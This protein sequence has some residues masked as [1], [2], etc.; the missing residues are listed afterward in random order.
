MKAVV[1]AGGAGS[2]LRPLTINRPKPMVPIVNKPILMHILDLIKRHNITDII[3]TL[4]YM[5]DVIQ[6]YLGDGKALGLN[7]RYAIEES[8]LGT[9]GSV[10]NAQEYLDETFV[11]ISGD[12]LT[13]FDLTRIISYHRS[14]NALAT[15]TLYR[16]PNPLEYGV[17]ITDED[18][19]VQQFQ[20]KPSWGEVISDTVNTGLYVLEPRVL[21]YFE[22]GIPF[23][24]SKDLFPLLLHRG[25]PLYGCVAEGYWCDV[26]NL[27]EYLRANRDVLEGRVHLEPLGEEREAGLWCEEKVEIAPD[28]QLHGP[29]FLGYGVKIKSGVTIHG[30]SVIRDYT[31]VDSRAHIDHSVVWRN[32]YIGEAVELR[33][34]IIGRQCSV[35]S[36][37]V[38]FEGAVIG[39]VSFIGE[40][41]IIH[42]N[43]KIWPEKVIEAGTTVKASVIWGSQ[44]RRI[45]FGRHGVTGLVNVDLTPEFA[46]KLGAAFAANLPTG[47][48]VTIGRDPHRSSRMIKRAIISGLPSAG[49]NVQ[50]LR[51]VPIPVTR[52]ITRISEAQGG[53]HVRLAP[54]DPRIVDIKFMNGD[55]SDLSKEAQRRIERIF[56]REDSRR[57]YLDEIGTIE[58]APRVIERYT[59]SFL[60]SL[61]V[62]AI[63]Q[64]GFYLIVDYASA[65]TS[66][67]L[68]GILAGLKCDVVALNANMD[69]NKMSVSQEEFN[70]SIRQLSLICRA[71]KTDL[72]VRIEVGGERIYLVDGEGHI[73]PPVSACA[74]MAYLALRRNPGGTIAVPVN[75]PSL[76]DRIASKYNGKIIRTRCNLTSLM[77]AAKSHPLIMAG[78]GN[79]NFIFP[80][81][82]P[83][84]DGLMAIA[85]L[86]EF[87]AT[88]EVALSQV[89][90]DLPPYFTA[91]RRVSCPWEH[92]GTVMRLLNE[93]YREHLEEQIDGVKI[94]MGDEWVLI[95]P[96]PDRPHFEIYAESGST[97]QA[98]ALADKYARIVE[99]LRE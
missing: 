53:I 62:D 82:Q 11:V 83:V 20:E 41:A 51:T 96:D 9:A 13:D 28:A 97:E 73:I 34:A 16:V 7:I 29:V 94:R 99:N 95:L 76:F 42:S 36:H 30:P 38:V 74:A 47:A 65:P 1:M 21:D 86:L 77:E 45:L 43:V 52:Y 2:R 4:Q 6:D 48:S 50:D 14:R 15:L 27:R 35:K 63:Q 75:M 68:P 89:L 60:S 72:G 85:K 31:V 39:D 57:V 80:H 58:Y 66:L 92:K 26:G 23:D 55:G 71:L 91:R 64:A 93:Q 17:V 88:E 59:E 54:Y 10:K 98:E 25:E 46:A 84:A 78:D 90:A 79:G 8:P 12:A 69:P 67:V 22:A 37:A 3:I 87:L 61:N 70:A 19:R 32:S 24:F 33:G 40:R 44:V 18:G 5:A 56:F 49:V 81:F